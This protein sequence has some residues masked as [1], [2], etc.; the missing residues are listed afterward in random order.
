MQITG[1]KMI[2]EIFK[3]ENIK[4]VFGYPGGA[5]MNVYDEIY[6]Q[7]DFQHI[8]VRHEQAAIHAADGYA[9]STG[10]VG[11]AIVT[12]GPGFTN[13]VTGLA[14]A[15][16]DSIPLVVLSGQVPMHLIGTDGFQEIDAVG[17]S[18]PC[19]KHNYLIKDIK[20]LPRIFKEAFH[21]AKSGRPGPVLIDLP[22]DISIH[23]DKFE[24]PESVNLP[25]YN[26]A[27]KPPI[28]DIEEVCQA[29]YKANKPIL[30][31]GGGIVRSNA[32]AE[33]RELAELTQI[34]ALE[35]VMARG[36]IG[37]DNE[38]LAH[39][40]L[41][42]VGMHGTYAANMGFY[43]CDLIICIG[44]RFDDRVTGKLSEFG[45]FAKIIHIDIDPASISKIVKADY[46]LIG[47]IKTTLKLL[48][49]KLK[50]IVNPSHYFK[51]REHLG[52]YKTMHPLVYKDSQ[53]DE[54]LKPQWVIQEI[55]K[56]LGDKSIIS[57]DVGQHQMWAAQFFPFSHSKQLISSSG[58]GTMGFGFPAGMGVQMA[59]PNKVSVAISGDGG[60]LMNIQE[61]TTCVQYGIPVINIILNNSFLGMVRQWQS[62]F[63][64]DRYSEVDLS[65]QPDF[66]KVAEAFGGL[67]FRATT[68][69]QFVSVFKQ[70]IESKKVC[71]I[72][73][74]IDRNENVLPMMPATAALN[75][76]I[77]LN[78][79]DQESLV[80]T[81]PKEHK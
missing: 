12:S 4:V 20:D 70:A 18:R 33:A 39:L 29:I 11:V 40:F 17:I 56:T 67:G 25:T 59:H 24:Y 64:D 30:Y 77:L 52:E 71:V 49:P 28:K 50:E 58:L 2:M 42:M 34:P 5:I 65:H 57:V 8:L 3:L 72:D 66:V 46:P 76:L 47:D 13:A 69:E 6:K 44:A 75:D 35:T 63:Y 23:H 31:L 9:R 54:T 37:D 68:K 51:W 43:E 15:Y 21:I 61:L 80:Y 81:I 14:T 19:T 55:G 1:S 38:K 32:Q 45:K 53:K 16:T 48:L 78:Q 26:P 62:F 79:E 7:S 36:V 10:E 41:G 74:V 60:V 27:L 22:K 73:V